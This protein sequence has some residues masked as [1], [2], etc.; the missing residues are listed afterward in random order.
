MAF[1]TIIGLVIAVGFILS[2]I[3]QDLRVFADANALLVVLG[4]TVGT[5][6][7]RYPMKMIA[8]LFPIITRAFVSRI[9]APD[10]MIKKILS[11]SVEAKKNGILGLEKV[12]IENDFLRKGVQ[13]A[14]DGVEPELIESVLRIDMDSTDRRHNAGSGMLAAAGDAAPA[15]GII[16]SLI[17]LVLMLST[18]NDPKNIGPALAMALLSILYGVALAH[19]LFFPLADKLKYFNEQEMLTKR[20]MI[21]GIIS[22]ANGD[23]PSVVQEKLGS[24]LRPASRNVPGER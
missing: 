9:D 22:I 21:N 6:F 13:L 2:A 18:M 7:I 15:F 23:H 3:G 10:A 24:F 16:G 20:L 17:G 19:V 11:L 4:G 8:G 5:I 1:S 14:V 12:K